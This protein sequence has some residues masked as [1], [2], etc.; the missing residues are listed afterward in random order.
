MEYGGL[1][2]G[3]TEQ[4]LQQCN[5]SSV[6]AR[7]VNFNYNSRVHAGVSCLPKNSCKSIIKVCEDCCQ[8]FCKK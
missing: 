4:S 3:G 7:Y 8:I 5:S 1:L 2:C 6:F